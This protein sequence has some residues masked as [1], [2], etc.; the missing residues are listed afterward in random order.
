MCKEATTRSMDVLF[1]NDL[2]KPAQHR[3]AADKSPEMRKCVLVSESYQKDE[4]DTIAS[5]STA[6][7]TD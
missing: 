7:E 5:K 2:K 3:V 4:Y 6:G 1:L